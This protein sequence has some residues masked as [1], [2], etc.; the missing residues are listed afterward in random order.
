LASTV[1]SVAVESTW[2]LGAVCSEATQALVV[3]SQA[4]GRACA[5]CGSR[6]TPM[7]RDGPVGPKT[8]CNACGI[9]WRQGKLNP[10]DTVRDRP[11]YVVPIAIIT[12][13]RMSPTSNNMGLHP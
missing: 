9:R 8:L 12:W 2:G 13:I 3:A 1:L 5:H 4:N 10:G 6:E 11:S 7:W